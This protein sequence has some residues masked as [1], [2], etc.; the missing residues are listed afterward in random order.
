MPC[1]TVWA[2]RSASSNRSGRRSA[3]LCASRSSVKIR[4]SPAAHQDFPGAPRGVLPSPSLRRVGET[5]DQGSKI[6]AFGAGRERQRH[7]VFEDGFGEI[8]RRR[9]CEGARRPSISAL[10]RTASIKAWLARGPGPQ[11]TKRSVSALGAGAGARRAHEL[12]DRFDHLVGHGD[13][14]HEALDAQQLAGVEHGIRRGV[15][16]CRWWRRACAARRRD[17]DR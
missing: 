13:L 15:L 8:D 17:P 7:A 11:A 4:P 2:M 10:A 14:A 6:L 5:Q 12:Q 9:R 16:R 3:T 1:A